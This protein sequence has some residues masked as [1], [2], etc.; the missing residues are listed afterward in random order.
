MTKKANK[1]FLQNLVVLKNAISMLTVS[2]IHTVITLKLPILSEV[3]KDFN[4]LTELEK[5]ISKDLTNHVEIVECM[6]KIFSVD[7]NQIIKD[8]EQ[9]LIFIEQMNKLITKE[10][11]QELMNTKPESNIAKLIKQEKEYGETITGEEV[12]VL[13]AN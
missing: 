11:A 5:R 9:T 2:T 10:Y 1:Q 8:E 13:V 12:D 3:I 4:D 6:E 7:N